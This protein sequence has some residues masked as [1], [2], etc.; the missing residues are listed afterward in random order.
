LR[1]KQK[2]HHRPDLCARVFHRLLERDVPGRV[3][4]HVY[5][6]EFQKRGLPHALI[7]KL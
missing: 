1:F 6:I 3:V 4:A 5:V 2:P 7:C